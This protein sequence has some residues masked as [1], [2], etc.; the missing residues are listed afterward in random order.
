MATWDDLREEER[1]RRFQEKYG[2]AGDPDP[3]ERQE[4]DVHGTIRHN[5][6]AGKASH[7]PLSPG[8]EKI[9]IA[10]EQEF[11]RWAGTQWDRKIRPSG[12]AG[13]N[14]RIKGQTINVITAKKPYNLIVER[15]K[16]TTDLY[17]LAGFNQTSRRAYLIG[18]AT[19]ADLKAKVPRDVGHMGVISHA[20][21]SGDLRSMEDLAKLLAPD[22]PPQPSQEKLF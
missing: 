5:L 22:P 13:I 15:G 3:K 17:V 1:R 9:G 21:P 16:L 4:Q 11:A 6:H 20:I 7:R 2:H 8:Y 18:W 10:G 14:F 12:S 19:K